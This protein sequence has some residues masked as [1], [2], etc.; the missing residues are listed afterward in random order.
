MHL[1]AS[2][3]TI[4]LAYWTIAPGAGH[5]VRHPGS[6]QCMHWSFR[7]S[8]ANPP[9][10]SCSRNLIRFQKEAWVSGIVW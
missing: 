3:S 8:Q 1:S 9:S 6:A 7:K 2:T 5:E 10:C 4:P